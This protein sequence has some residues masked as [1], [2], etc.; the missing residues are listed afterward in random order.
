MKLNPVNPCDFQRHLDDA[1]RQAEALREAAI[2]DFWRGADA[3]LARSLATASRSADRLRLALA[4][5]SSRS[6]ALEG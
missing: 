6:P 4:R 1:K 2:D 5:R 3:V